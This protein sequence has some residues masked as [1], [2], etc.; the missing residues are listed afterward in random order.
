MMMRHLALLSLML[1]W[2]F[3]LC[4]ENLEK[5]DLKRLDP[6]GQQSDKLKEIDIFKRTECLSCHQMIGKTIVIKEKLVNRCQKCHNRMPHSGLA[7]HMGQPLSYL[8]IGLKGKLNCLSCHRPHRATLGEKDRSSHYQRFNRVS[9]FVKKRKRE[10]RKLPAEL[11]RS[12]STLPMLK[13]FCIDCHK[14]S[15]LP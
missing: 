2:S 7:E 9:T 11:Y 6:H 12:N 3:S 5:L 4:A 14:G 1:V 15:N 13:R 10:L 8:K